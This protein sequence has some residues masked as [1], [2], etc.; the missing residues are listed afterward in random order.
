MRPCKRCEWLSQPWGQRAIRTRLLND[1]AGTG[2]LAIELISKEQIVR[3]DLIV[4]WLRGEKNIKDSLPDDANLLGSFDPH[5]SIPMK[6]P[7]EAAD[8]PG[9]LVLYSLGDQELVAVSKA[10]SAVK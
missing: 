2:Q 1:S 8:S 4:Y 10:F 9:V 5:N 7:Q 3:P 6:L